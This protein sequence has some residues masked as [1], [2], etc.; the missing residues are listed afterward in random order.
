M[1]KNQDATLVAENQKV[2]DDITALLDSVREAIDKSQQ[3]NPTH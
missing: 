1:G 2:A 3:T